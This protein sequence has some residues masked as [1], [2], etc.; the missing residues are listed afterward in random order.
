MEKHKFDILLERSLWYI[1]GS[2]DVKKLH[3]LDDLYK[4][5]LV[6]EN[7]SFDIIEFLKKKNLPIQDKF[8][9]DI[10]K[11]CRSLLGTCGISTGS[12]WRTYPS[13]KVNSV[14]D[15]IFPNKLGPDVEVKMREF[16]KKEKLRVDDFQQKY[17]ETCAKIIEKGGQ[18]NMIDPDL[19]RYMDTFPDNEEEFIKDRSK[20]IIDQLYD[21]LRLANNGFQGSVIGYL[22]EFIMKSNISPSMNI[23]FNRKPICEDF[24]FFTMKK[25]KENLF[26]SWSINC[27]NLKLKELVIME[28]ILSIIFAWGLACKNVIVMDNSTTAKKLF[29]V[30]NYIKT[31]KEPTIEN[32]FNIKY[33]DYNHDLIA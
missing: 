19:H 4:G 1:S 21:A 26:I 6:N 28:E 18:V 33:E 30:N 24:Y 13:H 7:T 3:P 23:F 17:Q 5:K 29:K 10:D 16:F 31:D 25:D 12:I 27:D 2:V 32:I 14:Y 20:Y 9:P 11:K 15:D 22:P 8:K